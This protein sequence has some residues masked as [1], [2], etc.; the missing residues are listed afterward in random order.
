MERDPWAI[1]RAEPYTERGVR[2]LDC[3]RCGMPARFQWQICADGNNYRPLCDV[4][5]VSLNELVLEF[6]LHP[7]AADLVE[8]YRT[9]KLG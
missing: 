1:K 4:C 7:R 3:I 2:R 8:A 6:M 9:E 5:D